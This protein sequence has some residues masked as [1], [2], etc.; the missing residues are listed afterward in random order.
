[1]PHSHAQ[2]QNEENKPADCHEYAKKKKREDRRQKE[3]SKFPQARKW[4]TRPR[5]SSTMHPIYAIFFSVSISSFFLPRG[6]TDEKVE[7]EDTVDELEM[8]R[9]VCGVASGS[10]PESAPEGCRS[11]SSGV[12]STCTVVLPRA[13]TVRLATGE[14]GGEAPRGDGSAPVELS[15]IEAR[16]CEQTEGEEKSEHTCTHREDT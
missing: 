10:L 3:R 16:L 2:T 6:D 12:A 8:P 15:L 1:M 13:V 11:A 14:V 7:L 4:R 5:P 9:S